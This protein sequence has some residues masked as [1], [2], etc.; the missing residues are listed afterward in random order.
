VTNAADAVAGALLTTAHRTLVDAAFVQVIPEL[1]A[2][3][4]YDTKED[5]RRIT[6]VIEEAADTAFADTV[7]NC[8]YHLAFVNAVVESLRGA[9]RD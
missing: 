4:S 1:L 6:G 8:M 7:F 9:S 5:M 3:Q 2:L